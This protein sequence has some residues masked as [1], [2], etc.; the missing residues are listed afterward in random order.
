LS[1][2]IERGANNPTIV[3]KCENIVGYLIEEISMMPRLGYSNEGEVIIEGPSYFTVIQE[4]L[5]INNYIIV[6][7]EQNYEKSKKFS[8]LPI[9]K[10]WEI[11]NENR[12]LK[13]R[14]NGER[15]K[16]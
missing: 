10:K 13:K 11:I 3:L 5:K 4:P 7:L 15:K 6:E 1:S 16:S 14:I 12:K 8:Y 2:F 9:P